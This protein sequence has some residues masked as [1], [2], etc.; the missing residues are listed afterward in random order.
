MKQLIS[1]GK[2]T[3]EVV[4]KFN[5][6]EIKPFITWFEKGKEFRYHGKMYDVITIKK[7]Q[8]AIVILAIEDSK[9]QHLINQFQHTQKTKKYLIYKLLLYMPLYQ[10]FNLF[11]R[12]TDI[13]FFPYF[14]ILPINII[15]ST[16]PPKSESFLLL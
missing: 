13:L 7:Q 3:P 15:P 2:Y 4:V 10:E 6:S 14:K 9:E 16:P 12:L 1:L 8:H 5:Y 11:T